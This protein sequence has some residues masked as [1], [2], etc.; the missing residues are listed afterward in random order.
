MVFTISQL[1]SIVSP[2]LGN[3]L[4][5]INTGLPF[6]F[7]AALSA[8]ALVTLVF[9]KRDWLEETQAARIQG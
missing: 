2:P 4:A 7:W 9:V 1:G 5:S 8:M 6:T 3:S